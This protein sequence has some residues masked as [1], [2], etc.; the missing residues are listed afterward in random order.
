MKKII[1]VTFNILFFTVFVNAQPWIKS[2][3]NKAKG[4]LSFYDYQKAFNAYWA[5][6]HVKYGKYID[7]EGKVRKASGWKQFKRWEWDM[8]GQINAET[9]KMPEKDA[10]ASYRK[11]LKNNP[12]KN[13]K[14]AN[15]QS[16]GPDFSYGG[17]A[18]IGRVNTIAFHPTDNASYWIAAPA[19]GLWHT[20][21]DGATWTCLTD[22]NPV[23]GISD[24]V[25]PSDYASS[26]TIY[27]AT[28]DRDHW[29]NRSVGV[30]KSE[31]N[32]NTWNATGI[33]FTLQE[34]KMTS[35]LLLDP[36]DD[37]T[38]LAATSE[39]VF[40]TTD[41][42]T[43]WNTSLSN[44]DFIDMEYKPGDFSVLYG[45]TDEG[46]IY[47]SSDAG[48]TWTEALNVPATRIELA[49]SPANPNVVYAIAGASDNGLYGIYKSDNS[50]QTFQQ[51]F[52]GTQ[53]G[54]N[55]LGWSD[56]D[57][58]GGQAWYDLS[59]A[60]SPTNENLVLIGGVNTWRSINGG[61]DWDMVNHWIGSY[62]KQAVHADKHMLKY[63]ANGDLFECNDGGIYISESNGD[64]DS[65]LDR[66]DGIVNSQMYKV[67]V[68]QTSP[69]DYIA[70]L[71]DNGT[72]CYNN[73]QWD[74]VIGGD[75]MNCLIDYTDEHI[76]YGSLYYGNIYK[77][78]NKWMSDFP[79]TP[80][81]LSGAWVTP[82]MLDPNNHERLYVGFA[83]LWRTDNGGVDWIQV[84]NIGFY[85]NIRS[86]AIA[87]SN[88]EVIYIAGLNSVWRTTDGGQNWEDITAGLPGDRKL[89]IAVKDNDPNKVWVTLGD[90]NSDNIYESSDGGNTWTN[91]SDGLPEL[92]VYSV[93][94]NKLETTE[95]NLYVGTQVGVYFKKGDDPW[96]AY[97]NGL[98]NVRIGEIEIYY[99]M[100]N[101]PQSQLFAATFGR[102][103]WKS[104]IELS[105]AFA[106][107]VSTGE[108]QN[109]EAYS[110]V[111]KGTVLNNFNENITENGML[112]STQNNFTQS[113]PGVIT[114]AA[115]NITQSGD[116]T[117][118][119]TNLQAGTR[120]YYKAYAENQ[121]GVGTGGIKELITS[122]MP[123]TEFPYSEDFEN[124][125]NMPI[126]WSELIL[127][128]NESWE[129]TE[130]NHATFG[131][132]HS[133]TYNALLKNSAGNGDEALLIL[134]AMN[135]DNTSD[136]A[137]ELSFWYAIPDYYSNIDE[138][139]VVYKRES[140]AEWQNLAVFS[141]DIREWTQAHLSLPALSG[142]CNIAFWGN[143]NLGLG[144]SID[145]VYVGKTQVGIK[146]AA[147]FAINIY[148]NP[149]KK[150]VI[151]HTGARETGSVKIRDINGK[152]LYEGILK[153][154]DLKIDL[155]DFARGTYLINI[156][157]SDYI[158]SE[159][160]ILN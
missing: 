56:G 55:L 102:G 15:W 61:T 69:N 150:S 8:E 130:G 29:D 19:G 98:P 155:S 116:F 38:I 54:N 142:V 27:I 71:Q 159:Q 139:K 136:T 93:V 59:I 11:W 138:L 43:N 144:I 2:L 157:I 84:S 160:L 44:R 106:P 9:G 153:N 96:V 58:N 63:R 85:D 111:L 76:Q 39:G 105:G 118:E 104:P 14:T 148:P 92:P 117:V 1:F 20:S 31:D 86:L 79:I 114:I 121:N 124:G 13:S 60:V 48:G 50:G 62:G 81:D 87:P 119:V 80:D 90:Y 65:W 129:F 7:K 158:Y 123:Y 135:F 112:I 113:T 108:A 66:T 22:N 140:D 30:L 109:I 94:Y 64:N 101:P 47:T 141:E 134:P 88:S 137:M 99:D 120:Y 52:D 26:G 89:D 107:A 3:P 4:E 143:A 67:G 122:C 103:L 42:G 41:G 132:A 74:D 91:I 40:K 125:G 75:G 127:S 33:S 147:N 115:D 35:R 10:A 126:C 53:S 146:K 151:V 110:A 78:T 6:Y 16:L 70:G 34:E 82:Y 12:N 46:T 68:S 28:G 73:S 24:I 57:D 77:T 51:V 21:N 156:I 152:L 83:D 49:V 17:Y 72:K 145:D 154:Q 5:P 32:G 25:I 131:T 37:Q 18:G 128:G 36:N 133:G 23:L 45:S 95:D 149:A 97:N 100:Q